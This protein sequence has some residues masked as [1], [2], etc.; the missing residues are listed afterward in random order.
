[1]A[2]EKIMIEVAYAEPQKQS[3]IKMAVSEGCTVEAAIHQSGVLIIF[4]QIDL[5]NQK[6]GIFSKACQLSDVVCAG[7]RIEI[8]RALT[9][10]PKEARRAKE[11]VREFKQGKNKSV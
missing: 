4:P 5:V 8:Y 10:D 3:I 6:V 9:I 1:M 2:I 11:K 7:D